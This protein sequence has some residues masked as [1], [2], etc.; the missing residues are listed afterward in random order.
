VAARLLAQAR[1]S[2]PFYLGFRAPAVRRTYADCRVRAA[3]GR[4]PELVR[5]LLDLYRAMA[6]PGDGSVET[7]NFRC[8]VITVA[9]SGE[10]MFFKEF[11]RHH[12][13]HDVERVL[14]CS[15]V[16]R[17]WRA[18]HLLPR[19]GI[20]TPRAVGTAFARL[21]DGRAMEYLATE[22]VDGALPYHVR[23]RR[24]SG[25]GEARVALLREFAGHLRLWHDR[26][27]YLRDLVKNV[28]T[29]ESERGLEFWLTDLDQLHPARRLT[30]G[31]LLHQMRQFARWV[32]PLAEEEANATVV[33]Y[34]GDARGR[35]AGIIK[36]V[37]LTTVPTSPA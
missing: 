12:L 31:R 32:G 7:I 30:S 28:L 23:L 21:E 36:E 11:P 27:V 37:L 22:W 6:D 18:A 35:M 4:E 25:D 13:L 17:A 14:R 33:S 24:V 16:D 29:R 1:L 9:E 2:L 19:A 15:R 8:A 34:L 10:R 3:A 26:G 5:E 20:L